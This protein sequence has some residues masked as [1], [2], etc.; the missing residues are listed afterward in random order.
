M[1]ASGRE[2]SCCRW[3]LP[4]LRFA[5]NHIRLLDVLRRNPYTSSAEIGFG[6]RSP[7]S[8]FSRSV[9]SRALPEIASAL[10]TLV[11]LDESRSSG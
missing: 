6:A 3:A 11:M 1:R 4:T 5:D 10:L 8:V 7:S 9:Q 2:I